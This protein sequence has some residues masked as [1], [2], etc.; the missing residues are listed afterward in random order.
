MHSKLSVGFEAEDGLGLLTA[1]LAVQDYRQG[2]DEQLAKFITPFVSVIVGIMAY[3][4]IVT[5]TIT[6]ASDLA[7]GKI[8]P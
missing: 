7:S 5:S 6:I 2:P 4:S 3:S 8:L 1:F